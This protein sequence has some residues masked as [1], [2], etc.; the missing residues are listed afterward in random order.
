[1]WT[2]G[3]VLIA[4]FLRLYRIDF[5]QYRGDDEAM[6][7]LARSALRALD[8]G[9]LPV[10][11]LF[12]SLGVDNGPTALYLL[13]VPVALF[14]TETAATAFMALVN[15]AA[16]ALTYPFTRSFFGP[17]VALLTTL[18]YATNPWLVVYSR[19][20][21]LNAA[22]PLFTLLFFW[23]LFAMVRWAWSAESGSG[24]NT[25]SGERPGADK[26]MTSVGMGL[27]LGLSLSSLAQVHLSGMAHLLTALVAVPL[28][29]LGRKPLALLVAAI[30]FAATFAPYFVVSVLPGLAR[31][32]EEWGA[33]SAGPEGTAAMDKAASSPVDWERPRQFFLLLTSRGY[34]SYASQGGRLLDTTQG[35]FAVADLAMLVAFLVGLVVA[36]H[37]SRREQSEA[38]LFHALLVLWAALPVLLLTPTVK[39]GKFLQVYPFYLLVTFP[40]VLVLVALGLEAIGQWLAA[41]SPRLL[42]VP[43]LAAFMVVAL[44]LVAAAVFFAVLH[45]YWS[46]ADYGLPLGH[47]M[48]IVDTTVQRAGTQPVMVGG[49]GDLPT[50]L[51][52]S[53]QHRGVDVRYFEDR[54]LVPVLEGES[55]VFYLTTDEDAWA[56][57][58]LL[59]TFRPQEE[60]VYV[61]PGSGWTARLFQLG[62]GQMAAAV[63]SRLPSKDMGRFADLA[64]VDSALVPSH[65]RVGTPVE[66]EVRWQFLRE[67]D[68]P[69]MTRLFLVDSDGRS[70]LLQEEVAYPAAFWR[71]GDAQRLVFFN[72]FLVPMPADV[73]PGRFTIAMRM[74]SIVDW[75]PV[76]KAVPLGTVQVTG[77]DEG[78]ASS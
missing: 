52:R 23:A 46:L 48:A 69:F 60:S 18:F 54:N 40:A 44:H 7:T 73:L 12:S 68:Q 26:P 20:A 71:G 45:E 32:L 38:K 35:V 2:L 72:R 6:F 1:M 4:A 30:S 65:V 10:H 76:G 39:A 63:E 75:N 11:G 14:G 8:S 5:A 64:V 50:V 28:A 22:V 3:I 49:H 17:R 41:L 57:R 21:W 56:T 66:V 61:V 62:P 31:V 33:E 51:Y 59:A 13:M 36:F 78:V 77:R 15:T 74:V 25:S 27:F 42:A 16:V 55:S 67:P 53:L 58:Y 9:S 24:G 19:R 29:R 34:Q 47:A 37:R 43:R 70:K